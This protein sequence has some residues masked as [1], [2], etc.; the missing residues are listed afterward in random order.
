[1]TVNW[2]S[3]TYLL[4]V[5]SAMSAVVASAQAVTSQS[6]SYVIFVFVAH[7]ITVF[8]SSFEFSTFCRSVWSDSVHVID[9]Q[10]SDINEAYS[11][12]NIEFNLPL[13]DNQDSDQFIV[14]FA[15]IL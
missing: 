13:I 2:A 9:H 4:F 10:D 6:A 14:C 5:L 8:L 3:V 12:V 15:I 11:S 1:M 7:V